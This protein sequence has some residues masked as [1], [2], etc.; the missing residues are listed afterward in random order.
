MTAKEWAALG[1]SDPVERSRV[2]HLLG[3]ETQ[4]VFSTLAYACIRRPRPPA[5]VWRSGSG[6]QPWDRRFLRPR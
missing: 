1:S 4:L 5:P 2:F 6:T 3:F